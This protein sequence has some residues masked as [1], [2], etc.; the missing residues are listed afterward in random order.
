MRRRCFAEGQATWDGGWFDHSAFNTNFDEQPLEPHRTL[1]TEV[2][3]LARSR[4]LRAARKLEQEVLDFRARRVQFR[5]EASTSHDHVNFGIYPS[6]D[7]TDRSPTKSL[8]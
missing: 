1:S 4:L 2:P 8:I 7:P 5:A 3:L 6:L